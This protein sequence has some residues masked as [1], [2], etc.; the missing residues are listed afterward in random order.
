MNTIL[1]TGASGYLA[2]RLVPISCQYGHVVGTARQVDQI[3][4]DAEPHYLDIRDQHQ[5]DELVNALQPAVIIHT[6]ACNPGPDNSQMDAINHVGTRHIAIAAARKRCRLVHVSTDV[7]HDGLNAPYDDAAQA[8]P[9]NDYGRSKALGEQAVLTN[10]PDSIAVR[11]SL[12]YGL[13]QMDR[14]TEGFQ[15]RIAD[16]NVL[17]LFSDVI[18]QPVWVDSLALALVELAFTHTDQSGL[19]NIAGEQAMSRADFATRLLRHWQIDIPSTTREISGADVRGV[20]LDLRLNLDRATRL[21]FELP[22]V[23]EVL[24]RHAS[25]GSKD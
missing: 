21:G 11:T 3:H 7:V 6:A 16:G 17:S 18:R 22:G 8:D 25:T 12:I 19:L 15:Q 23:D 9:I 5:V 1:V 24:K 4:A 13:D 2:H 10:H 14:G 20:P